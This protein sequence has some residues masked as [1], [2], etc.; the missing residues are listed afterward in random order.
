MIIK[1]V[2]SDKYLTYDGAS[3]YRNSSKL[4]FSHPF[5]GWMGSPNSSCSY[6]HSRL[7]YYH[8]PSILPP[9]KISSMSY[10]PE[11]NLLCP[12]R[13]ISWISRW[14][15][16][17]SSCRQFLGVKGYYHYLQVPYRKDHGAALTE[18]FA[19]SNISSPAPPSQVRCQQFEQYAGHSESFWP[20]KGYQDSLFR[21]WIY[22]SSYALSR[23]SVKYIWGTPWLRRV[24]FVMFFVWAFRR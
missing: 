15:C 22:Q 6:L 14:N 7:Q 5:S 12:P 9:F 17:S 19:H 11:M 18:D 3:R 24:Y 13:N 1:R 8:W 2:H 4:A 21:H 16:K 10:T 23:G 20:P